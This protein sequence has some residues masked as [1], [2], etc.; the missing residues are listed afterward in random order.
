MAKSTKTPSDE[1]LIAQNKKAFFNYFLSDFTEAGIVLVGS[2]IKSLRQ[3]HCS[4]SDS[5]VL[6]RGG[7]AY[8]LNM[9]IPVYQEHG[10]FNAEPTRT[11]KLLLH[12]DQIR[13]FESA[14]EKEGYALIP[15]RV[16]LRKG[17]AKVQIALGKGKKTWDKR[18]TIRKR[19]DDRA[20]QK[21]VKERY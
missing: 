5:Y 10:L 16:Y 18:E 8:L 6:I 21:A 12:K 13:H 9:N 4:I 20:L 15:T 14:V 17:R 11:R 7:E 19:E 2:E 3:G 1:K